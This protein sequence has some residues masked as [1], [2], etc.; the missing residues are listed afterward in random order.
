[1]TIGK[2]SVLVK[3][4]PCSSDLDQRLLFLAEVE[5]SMPQRRP[6]L[7]LDCSLLRE[8]DEGAL[9]MMLHC[10]EATL[11]R[12]G[13]VKLAALPPAVGDVFATARLERLFDV[14]ETTAEAVAS[15]HKAPDMSAAAA[16]AS[17][18]TAPVV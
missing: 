1:M 4:L 13:D 15:F 18:Q 8:L 2:R 5:D 11:K 12:N 16:V 10:L 7:V 6:C 9:H 3:Q 17:L 14:Y